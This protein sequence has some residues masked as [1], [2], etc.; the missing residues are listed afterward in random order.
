LT[1]TLEVEGGM[2]GISVEENTFLLYD[3]MRA[4]VIIAKS[5]RVMNHK[6]R[7]EAAGSWLQELFDQMHESSSFRPSKSVLEPRSTVRL[8][9]YFCTIFVFWGEW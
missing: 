9:Q 3:M 1:V 8:L 6:S 2:P 5:V 4:I 7:S